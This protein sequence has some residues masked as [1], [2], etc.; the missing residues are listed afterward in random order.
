MVINLDIRRSEH[1]KRILKLTKKL[2]LK[3]LGKKANPENIHS[4]LLQTKCPA[5]LELV[6]LINVISDKT[7]SS[8]QQ[9]YLKTFGEFALWIAVNHPEYRKVLEGVLSTFTKYDNV[10]IDL[11]PVMTALDLL[12][13]DSVIRF[14]MKKML[15]RPTY[16]MIIEES[17]TTPNKLCKYFMFNI[18]KALVNIKNDFN[19][20][21]LKSLA[22][23]VLWIGV[24]D[25]AYRHQLYY[26]VNR[27]GNNDLKNISQEFYEEPDKW[28]INVY[29][30]ARNRSKD[31]IKNKELAMHE[32]CLAEEQC[33]Q[34]KQ[35][36][37][38]N[39]ILKRIG[40]GFLDL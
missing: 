3:K 34:D 6:N 25:T 11:K 40:G 27:I 37:K 7:K 23:L 10:K 20:T 22:W 19:N 9:K 2:I 31:L 18:D 16:K 35:Q 33:C 38:I 12:V 14:G 17:F 36:K 13:F 8:Y 39:G 1:E 4:Y 15:Q 30:D 32:C 21:A 5:L 26:G 28:F 24:N 29:T